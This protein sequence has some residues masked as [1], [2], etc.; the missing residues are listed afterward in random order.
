M[1]LPK[2][3]LDNSYLYTKSYWDTA[4]EDQ[5]KAIVA[6][7]QRNVAFGSDIWNEWNRQLNRLDFGESAGGL[8][9]YF[10]DA[11]WPE[12]AIF[13]GYHFHTPVSFVR[14]KFGSDTDSVSAFRNAAFHDVANFTGAEFYG[15]LVSFEKATFSGETN[16]YRSTLSAKT[17]WFVGVD[18][19]SWVN[20]QNSK[21]LG[22]SISFS[23]SKFS[24]YAIFHGSTFTGR[25]NFNEVI[26]DGKS[27]LFGGLN[28]A[29][30]SLSFDSSIFT[31]RFMVSFNGSQFG[32]VRFNGTQFNN[33]VYCAAARFTD[34][35]SFENAVFDRAIGFAGSSFHDVP[36]FNFT[37]F[38]QPPDL[39][40]LQIPEPLKAPQN[41]PLAQRYERG[42]ENSPLA[43]RYRK[44]KQ[45]AAQA[46][47]HEQELKFFGYEMR[48]KLMRPETPFPYKALI[49]LY[50]ALSK[51]GQSA[52]RPVV[53]LLLIFACSFLLHAHFMQEHYTDP[54]GE[55]G[56]RLACK[57]PGLS[58][59]PLDALIRERL[60]H[61]LFVL[62]TERAERLLVMQC[63]Y[64]K[65]KVVPGVYRFLNAVHFSVSAL[66]LFLFGLAVRNRLKVK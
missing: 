5:R 60:H 42:A 36:D 65:D 53:A 10:D 61:T 63:V 37:S 59:S 19:G 9:I 21:C 34:K 30:S 64:G 20:F 52:T 26:F 55:Q 66:L 32:M 43:Q 54:D 29:T 14:A 45:L 24:G 46:G 16:F 48:S 39:S 27:V 47:D 4:S 3:T 33:P 51:F 41:S 17:V 58:I 25:V 11:V 22:S 44:L 15:D 62:P 28:A 6:E 50:Q 8:C 1:S 2:P 7:N 56:S 23:K 57:T 13:S 35:C 18:F 49:W 31:L 40:T 12:G 38:R